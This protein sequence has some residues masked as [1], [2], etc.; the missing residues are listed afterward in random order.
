MVEYFFV[1]LKNNSSN[2]LED[3]FVIFL[4]FLLEII[5]DIDRYI[6]KV[7]IDIFINM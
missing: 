4:R 2:I 3:N 6:F 5:F 1:I 7:F